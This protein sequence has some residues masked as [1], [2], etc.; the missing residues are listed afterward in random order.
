MI[1]GVPDARTLLSVAGSEPLCWPHNVP[2]DKA[3]RGDITPSEIS[4]GELKLTVLTPTEPRLQA[5]ADLWITDPDSIS[6][7]LELDVR[8]VV[9][10][11]ASEYP[12]GK[13]K[14]DSTITNPASIT[15]L[16]ECD[17]KKVLMT[18]DAD[19]DDVLAAIKKRGWL[20][21]GQLWLDLM[22]VP[23]HGSDH[24]SS[25]EFLEALP[26]RHYLISANGLNDNPDLK[27]VQRLLAAR[28]GNDF[29]VHM[30]NRDYKAGRDAGLNALIEAQA[31]RGF[32]LCFRDEASLSLTVK[33]A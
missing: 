17:D 7:A 20:T 11:I 18:G 4:Y 32:G 10:L 2:F 14:P 15:F 31:E 23:H 8:E 1:E 5:L 30:T 21:D 26:A 25:L 24:N 16:L 9:S 19:G 29:T 3:V 12:G 27:T 28:A 22:K 33:L 13:Y 6:R